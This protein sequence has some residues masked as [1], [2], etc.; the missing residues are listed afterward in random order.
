MERKR[1]SDSSLVGK[2]GVANSAGVVGWYVGGPGF[3]TLREAQ[4]MARIESGRGWLGECWAVKFEQHYP[5]SSPRV[6]SAELR[7]LADM[8]GGGK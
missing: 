7:L 6:R 1:T 4:R 3:D 8:E 5:S 2:Y